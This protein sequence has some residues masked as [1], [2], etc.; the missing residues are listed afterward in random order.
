MSLLLHGVTSKQKGAFYCLNCLYF[1]R[2]ENKPKFHKKACKYKDFCGIVMPLE[3]DNILE[4]NQYM[5]SD[6]MPCIIY[7]DIKSLIKKID[8]CV[9]NPENSSTRK[10]GEQISCRYSMS[11]IWAFDNK[12]NEHIFYHG[13]DCMKMFCTSLR[14]HIKN[15]INFEN[16]KMLPLT[17]EELKPH[18]DAKVC[19]IC[20]KRI[21]KKLS[22]STKLLESYRSLPLY[23]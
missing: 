6:K 23:R 19:Y 20:E 5:E 1:F 22:K 4:F 3:N 18:Q 16:K 14:G 10:I 9:N 15:I 21:L 8:G 12:E 7:A 2:T 11:T 17:K 13:E